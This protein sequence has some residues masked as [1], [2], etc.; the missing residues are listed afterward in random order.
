MS[1]ILVYLNNSLIDIQAYSPNIDKR[2]KVT[3]I[4]KSDC[5][6]NVINYKL[7]SDLK[8]DS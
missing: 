2:A 7:I 8:Q 6:R 1:L 4:F 3:A 5:P